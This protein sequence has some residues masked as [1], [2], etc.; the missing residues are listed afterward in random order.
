[1]AEQHPRLASAAGAEA[2]DLAARAEQRSNFVAV[3]REDLGLRAS[4]VILRQLADFPEERGAAFIVEILARQRAR[5][6]RETC[7][8]VAQEVGSAG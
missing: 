2:D 5:R 1:V 8:R 7:D 4:D 6:T 3:R